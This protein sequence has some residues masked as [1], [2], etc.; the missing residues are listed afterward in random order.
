MLPVSWIAVRP[1]NKLKP[2]PNDPDSNKWGETR[3]LLIPLAPEFQSD[4]I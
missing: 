4:I 3:E 1:G 2:Q